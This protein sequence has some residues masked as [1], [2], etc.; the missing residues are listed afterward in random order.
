[1]FVSFFQA[2][3]LDCIAILPATKAVKSIGVGVDLHA[4]VF[5][6][7]KRTVKHVVSVGF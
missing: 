1:V 5:I 3:E 7:M 6:F 4:C 2:A